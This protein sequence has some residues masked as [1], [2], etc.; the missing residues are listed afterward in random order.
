MEI[1]YSNL[2]VEI[3]STFLSSLAGSAL[4][5]MAFNKITKSSVSFRLSFIFAISV[6]LFVGMMSPNTQPKFNNRVETNPPHSNAIVNPATTDL[7]NNNTIPTLDGRLEK[8]NKRQQM[9]INKLSK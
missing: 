1:Q 4:A 8:E 9:D 7:T 5:I 2:L 6:T 3:V